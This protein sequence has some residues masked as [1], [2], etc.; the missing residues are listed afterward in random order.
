MM[1]D[2]I[3]L[4]V[5]QVWRPT[6]GGVSRTTRLITPGGCVFQ[7]GWPSQDGPGFDRFESFRA[8]IRCS[9]AEVGENNHDR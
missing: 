4:A 3:Q 5:G 7:E 1:P 9:Q 6:V 8:W 2:P